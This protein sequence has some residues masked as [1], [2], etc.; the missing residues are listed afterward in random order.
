MTNNVFRQSP[1]FKLHLII[2]NKSLMTVSLFNCIQEVFL[3][4][5]MKMFTIVM[6]NLDMNR[7]NII[8]SKFSMDGVLFATSLNIFT[9]KRDWPRDN[10][11]F[12]DSISWNKKNNSIVRDMTMCFSELSPFY[13]CENWSLKWVELLIFSS[14]SYPFPPLWFSLSSL[15]YQRILSPLHITS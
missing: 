7:I 9:I 11:K 8:F 15:R 10:I 6:I 2:L 14:S 3:R 13:L 5:R 12:N 1:P 4:D